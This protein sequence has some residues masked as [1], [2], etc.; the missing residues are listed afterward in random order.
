MGPL[1]PRGGLG[2]EEG[3]LAADAVQD[4]LADTRV[5]MRVRL[6]AGVRGAGAEG[7][8]VLVAELL[9]DHVAAGLAGHPQVLLERPA[10]GVLLV[11]VGGESVREREDVVADVLGVVELM[12][13]QQVV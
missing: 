8:A 13:L 5:V 12:L 6:R 9:V 2:G 7:V 1:C 11:L 3:V 4:G 10:D